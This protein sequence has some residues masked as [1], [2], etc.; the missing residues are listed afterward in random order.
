MT[1]VE[2]KELI[3][4][5]LEI[6]SDDKKLMLSALDYISNLGKSLWPIRAINKRDVAKNIRR[7]L[8]IIVPVV[9]DDMF[10]YINEENELERLRDVFKVT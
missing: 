6:I 1:I 4:Q 2:I 10:E 5:Q 8:N 9:C 3:H 7:N